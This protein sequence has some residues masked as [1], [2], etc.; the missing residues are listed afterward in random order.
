MISGFALCWA[1]SVNFEASSIDT[2]LSRI[3]TGCIRSIDVYRRYILNFNK[4]DV[5]KMKTILQ[6]QKNVTKNFEKSCYRYSTANFCRIYFWNKKHS[7]QINQ[8]P[9]KI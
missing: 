1:F 8:T 4:S 9:T 5:S 6:M 2:K 3:P 7:Q